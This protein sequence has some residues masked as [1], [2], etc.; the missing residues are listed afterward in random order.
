MVSN[1]VQEKVKM[2]S[3]NAFKSDMATSLLPGKGN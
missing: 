1:M 3:A 2:F